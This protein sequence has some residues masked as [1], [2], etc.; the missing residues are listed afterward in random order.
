MTNKPGKKEAV[1][2]M[3]DSI[4]GKYDFL[5]HFLSAGIDYSWRKRVAK[6][7]SK[8]QARKILDVATGTADLA[9][10]VSRRTQAK[11]TGID[12]S[13]GM[14][15][16]GIKKLEQKKLTQQI[17]LI[18]ADSENLPF[19]TNTFDVSMVAF[20]VRN[21]ENLHQGLVEMQRVTQPGGMIVVLEFSKPTAFPVKQLYLVYFR[22]IL[23]HLG[24]LISRDQDAYTYLPDSVSQ[25]PDG[26]HFQNE[27]QKAGFVE[28][29]Q[30]RLSFGIATIYT[31]RKA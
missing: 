12:I 5:N 24:R 18:Q 20:G 17:N 8:E 22:F 16:I 13:A 2:T 10:A 14:L 3:F 23:P 28:T 11:I 1:R 27:L 7:V 15:D 26:Q 30:R 21:F 29:K 9:I 25:F 4:A 19:E 6:I 31:G